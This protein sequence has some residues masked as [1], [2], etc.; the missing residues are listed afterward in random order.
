[1]LIASYRD[2]GAAGVPPLTTEA[3]A[4]LHARRTRAALFDAGVGVTTME[5]ATLRRD[6]RI[7]TQ[8]GAG[9]HLVFRDVSLA[10]IASIACE[11]SAGAGH[12]GEL[13][14]RADSP[15]GPLVGRVTVPETGQWDIWKTVAAPVADP[16]G[17]RDLYVVVAESAG[18]QRKKLN[19]DVLEFVSMSNLRP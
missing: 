2:R 6:R 17:V 3:H 8:L 5:V 7:C 15:K 13:E 4:V 1:V 11:V 9:S 18:G 12:G 19:L 10:G 14:F 16:G